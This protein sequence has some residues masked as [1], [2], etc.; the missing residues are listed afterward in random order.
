[1]TVFLVTKNIGNYEKKTFMSHP[2]I[3]NEVCKTY[4]K[5]L[6][7]AGWSRNWYE[8]EGFHEIHREIKPY[9][10][11]ERSDHLIRVVM[12]NEKENLWV[13]IEINRFFVH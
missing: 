8:K 7:E 13:A 4:S 1:M 2:F 9:D 5:A 3:D 6:R 10:N 12:V 11:K